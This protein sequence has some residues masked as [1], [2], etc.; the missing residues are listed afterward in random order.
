MK[1][2]LTAVIFL[3]LMLSLSVVAFAAGY[4]Y[5]D[6]PIVYP[7]SAVAVYGFEDENGNLLSDRYNYEEYSITAQWSNS[8][9]KYIDSVYI[10]EFYGQAVVRF[11]TDLAPSERLAITGELT[12]YQKETRKKYVAEISNGALILMKEP[13]DE[14]TL[15]EIDS[16]V[17]DLPAGYFNAMTV[18]TSPSGIPIGDLKADF[19][20][21]AYFNVALAGDSAKYMGYDVFENRMLTSKYPDTIMYFVT[22]ASRPSFI[23]TGT[24]GINCYEEDYY[25][26]E[27]QPDN[28]LVELK[29]KYNEDTYSYEISTNKL[30]SYVVSEKK[31]QTSAKPVSSSSVAPPAPSSSVAPPAPSSSVAPPAPSSSS[32]T[33]PAPSSSSVTPPASSSVSPSSSS[34]SESTLNPVSPAPARNGK[35]TI[36]IVATVALA[37]ILIL[38]IIFSGN[39]KRR[40]DDWDD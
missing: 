39:R 4:G 38:V 17:Y 5:T 24:L 11:K 19:N 10:D 27:I 8:S 40:T 34:Q 31:L 3:C 26:Y 25:V 15:L 21:Y 6:E 20:G 7:G 16:K 9:K 36:I 37:V 13:E 23:K 12:L 29:A 2:I 28:S 22:F 33:P 14:Y 32:V 18:F 1:K 30:T 35:T